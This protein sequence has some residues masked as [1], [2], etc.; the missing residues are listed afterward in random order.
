VSRRFT[1]TDR[2]SSDFTCVATWVGE[3]HILQTKQGPADDRDMVT[4]SVHRS[5]LVDHGRWKI[6]GIEMQLRW[7][8][9]A[10]GG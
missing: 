3:H 8:G 10:G 6:H 5:D 1:A 4:I 9:D 7:S 2:I